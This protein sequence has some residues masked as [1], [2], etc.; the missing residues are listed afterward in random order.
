VVTG[1]NY[2]TQQKSSNISKNIHNRLSVQVS[3]TGLSFL[4]KGLDTE[5]ILYFTEKNVGSS[6]TAEELL[7]EID[8]IIT[9]NDILQLKFDEVII[10]YSNNVYTTVPSS[11]FDE[12]K[13]SEYLK[14]NSK[15][16][17][18]DFIAFDQIESNNMVVV[19]IPYVNI[20]NYFFER[21]GSFQYYHAVSVFLKDVLYSA[22][23][24]LGPKMYL[25]VQEEQ[26]DF[27]ILEQGKLVLCN[28]F[29]FKTSEDFIYYVLFCLEQLRLNPDTIPVILSG[30]IE[31]EDS[32]YEILYTYIRNI[33][34]IEDTSNPS[35]QSTTEVYHNNYL[36]KNVH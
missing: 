20:N 5:E 8:T 13:A 6:A 18:N 31:K 22:K 19:Y 24:S 27:I 23:H 34:F 1:Q 3:L 17:S 10:L 33:L 21:F 14:F 30:T 11:L 25:N 15:I 35:I 4:V 2:M 12:T 32:N 9:E 28:S 29:L 7:L 26:L 16:L 36:L